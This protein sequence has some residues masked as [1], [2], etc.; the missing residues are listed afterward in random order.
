MTT[1]F[2]QIHTLT[3]YHASLLNRDDAGFAKRIPFGG[4][5]RT[6]ISSQCLK[7]HWRRYDGKQSLQDIDGAQMSVRSRGTFER[8]VVEPLTQEGVAEAIASAIANKLQAVVLGQKE[9]VEKKTKPG[10]ADAPSLFKEEEDVAED[11]GGDSKQ[12]TV[13]GRV[14]LDYLLV[15]ARRIA[16]EP[17]VVAAAKATG[18]DASKKLSEE[19][20]KHVDN[21][22]LRKNLENLGRG[23]EG[24]DAAVFGRMV[25]S[26]VLSRTDAAVHVAHAFTV[27]AEDSE[28]DYF[29]AIDDLT[30]DAG[31]LGSGH[32]NST[33]LT[34]GLFYSYVC[35]DLGQ[36]RKNLIGV[37]HDDD[38]VCEVVRRLIHTI[39]CVSPGAK[40]GSTAPF[41]RAHCVLVEVGDAQPRS[42]ANAFLKPVSERPD[43]LANAY[44]ALGSHLAEMDGM[45][46]TG[47][48]RKGA[49][50]GPKGKLGLAE[51]ALAA[52]LAEVADFAALATME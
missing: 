52:S 43:V 5:V 45:Y 26:D 38:T 34:T 15:L 13:L 30:A 42:L 51:G 33:E 22:D 27:H 10:K 37:N 8:F 7:R 39:A 20:A 41:S 12:V 35:I 31:E 23:A 19:I 40:K 3:P 36:L 1:R 25:T 47:E 46:A 44:A 11:K 21:K 24:L 49:A 14:E 4:A 16:N 18:K 6:R 17:A 50:I 2:I 28:S 32:I 48:Q 9:K 29:S